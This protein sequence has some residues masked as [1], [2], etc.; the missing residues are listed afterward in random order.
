MALVSLLAVIDKDI[1]SEI[2]TRFGITALVL[3]VVTCVVLVVFSVA[4]EAIPRPLAAAVLWVVMFFTAMTGLGRGFVSEEER[5]TALLLR[6]SATSDAVFMGKL[7]VNVLQ[8]VLANLLAAMLFLFFLPKLQ[9]GNTGLFLIVVVVGSLG[10]ATALTVVS[11]IVAKAGTKNALLPVL[12]FPVLLPL[13]MPG[14][15]AM[16]MAFAGS[17]VSEAAGNLVLMLAYAGIVSVITWLVFDY[18]WAD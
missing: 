5:G 18:I 6:L 10:L 16:L 14:T 15:D 8:A 17:P 12:S 13:V 2:R 3:F 9:V 4:D 7:V 1:R 11:A